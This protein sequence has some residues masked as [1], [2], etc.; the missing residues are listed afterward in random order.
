VQSR[1]ASGDLEGEAARL[2]H[3][4][5]ELRVVLTG[6]ETEMASLMRD[7]GPARGGG[8]GGG[9]SSPGNKIGFAIENNILDP[10]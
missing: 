3:E 5:R 9:P 2:R 8:G 4:V 6:Q 7:R 10:E 1:S